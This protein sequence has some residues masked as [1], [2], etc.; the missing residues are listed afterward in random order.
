MGKY[1][2]TGMHGGKMFVRKPIEAHQLGK[3]VG[4]S[5]LDAEDVAELAGYLD[6]YCREVGLQGDIAVNGQFVKLV[7]VSHRPYGKIYA[8]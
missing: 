7:P 1:V 6:E 8:Y 5:E 2:G 3:E 4:M